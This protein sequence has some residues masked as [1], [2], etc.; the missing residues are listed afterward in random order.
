MDCST[1]RKLIHDYLDKEIQASSL[2]KLR[3]HI[4]ECK[5]CARHLKELEKTEALLYN[6]SPMTISPQFTAKVLEK[7]PVEHK[8]K[9][10]GRWFRNHPFVTAAS[11][12]LILMLGSIVSAWNADQEGFSFSSPK[13][14]QLII[15]H[16]KIIVPEGEVVSGDLIVKNGDIEVRG[17]VEGNVVAID[18]KV[19][20]AST[21]YI[22]GQTKEIDE[23]FEWLS[24]QWEKGWNWVKGKE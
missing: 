2:R 23:F 4:K 20:L 15:N 6:L 22:T 8:S 12:F 3:E 18:G 24:F 11:L 16:E 13:P 21:A 10:I 9:R 14:Q 1:S 17:R 5:D 19:Y 7:L